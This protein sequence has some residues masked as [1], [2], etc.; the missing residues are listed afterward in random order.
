MPVSVENF[1]DRRDQRLRG[2]RDTG[3]PSSIVAV[4]RW[5]RTNWPTR[6]ANDRA[7][8]GNVATYRARILCSPPVESP[9]FLRCVDAKVSLCLPGP[10]PGILE[11]E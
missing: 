3:A 1:A 8:L 7:G 11:T 5:S 2:G 4:G 9:I 10:R 6:L